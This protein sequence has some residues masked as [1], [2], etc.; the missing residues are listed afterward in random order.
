MAERGNVNVTVLALERS[1][2][3][4]SPS[5]SNKVHYRRLNLIDVVVG[6]FFSFSNLNHS[7]QAFKLLGCCKLNFIKKG[8]I[9]VKSIGYAS[10]FSRYKPNF[11]LAHFLSE[12]STVAMIAAKILNV[13]F[14]ISA[15]A[16]D[17]TVDPHCPKIKILNSKF[18]VVCNRHAYD[19]CVKLIS[20]QNV[21]NLLLRYHGID[22]ATFNQNRVYDFI[23]RTFKLI[24]V[25]RFEEKKGHVFLLQAMKVLK[26]KG[27]NFTLKLIG[28]GALY[29]DVADAIIKLELEDCVQILG[30]GAGLP[31]KDTLKEM[32]N[33]D[34]FVFSG[35]NTSKGDADGIA[36][37]LIEASALS[38]PVVSTDSGSTLELIQNE[39]NGLVVPQRDPQ[40]LAEAIK[41][42]YE[43]AVLAER[44]GANARIK[45]ER[46]FDINKNI[47]ELESLILGNI[48]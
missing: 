4:I 15:H 45:V 35:I 22:A 32:E 40:A 30:N 19:E 9:F 44:L 38:M 46:D 33:S 17:V 20:G 25:A 5:L 37:V 6:F 12:P 18:T 48:K 8:H 39:Q 31:F 2:G 28:N 29:Q 1:S 26:A 41:R 16:K 23:G 11:I 24:N 7:I 43:D 42:L 10:I 21:T 34:L 3:A 27:F 14:G 47:V 36:N 13:P